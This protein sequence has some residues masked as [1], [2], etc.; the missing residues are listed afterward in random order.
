MAR[1]LRPLI[2]IR[3]ARLALPSRRAPHHFTNIATGQRLGY[4]R[5]KDPKAAGRWVLEVA[6]G[7]GGEWQKVV[8]TADDF[9]A[10]DG[11]HVL[12]FWQAAETA[13]NL[14]RG[15]TGG[16]PATWAQALDAYE[17]DLTARDGSPY[18]ARQVKNH[19]DALA[20]ALLKKPVA[21]LTAHEL[22]NWR[23]AL[24]ASHLEASSVVRVLKS[25]RASLNLAA[26]HDPRIENRN[27]WRVGLGGITDPGSSIDDS[28]VVAPAIVRKIVAEAYAD[29]AALG[30]FM[31]VAAETG[32]RA[33]QIARLVVADLLGDRLSMPSS[34]KGNS[35]A[36]T[37]TPVPISA[38]LAARLAKAG[39]KRA[40]HE[41][42]LTR[43]GVAW[44]LAKNHK[45]LLQDPF[46]AIA[47]RLGIKQTMYTLRHSSIVRAL[48]ANV[49][50]Q[51]VANNHDT[52]LAMLQKTY[53]R[54][55]SH[56]GEDVA[57]RG[58]LAIGNVVSL[59][60]RRA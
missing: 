56:H 11:V 29:D 32:A 41:P 48:L 43:D 47:D 10:A 57:R 21:L 52:S 27:A 23:N 54:F 28:R 59:E 12:D 46:K 25:A 51:L 37:H 53:A 15:E 26:R 14:A 19:L 39:G 17:K 44:D 13:R 40:P 60:E 8:G 30:L 45:R 9:E 50:A 38:D 5:M 33:S 35:R 6:N 2:S 16:Q 18:N 3:D 24:K 20:P 36:I 22:T 7:K 42:L 55:I 4:R 34:R 58:L 31:H 1:K 49:P